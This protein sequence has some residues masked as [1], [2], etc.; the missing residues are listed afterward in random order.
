MGREAKPP[1]VTK[2]QLLAELHARLG[3]CRA[4]IPGKTKQAEPR[5]CT[6]WAINERGYCGQHY[7]SEVEKQLQS[8]RAAVRKAELLA[9]IDAYI[10]GEP[11]R[12]RATLTWVA[13]RRIAILEEQRSRLGAIIASLQE[14]WPTE[15]S[16]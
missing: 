12:Q 15:E 2:A 4:M 3:Q 13:R 5:P 8:E 9:Q 16:T 14:P 7:A 11:E 6:N 1:R 10:A